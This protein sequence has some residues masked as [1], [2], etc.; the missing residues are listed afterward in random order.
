MN[1]VITYSNPTP[2]QRISYRTFKRNFQ[3]GPVSLNFLT[4]IIIFFLALFYLIQSQQSA[5]KVYAIKELQQQKNEIISE[6]EQLKIR[7]AELNSIENIK[8]TASDLQM[9]PSVELNYLESPMFS[10]K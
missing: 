5:S 6:N 1:R 2:L 8:N 10:K 4:I 3:I 9:V 7:A